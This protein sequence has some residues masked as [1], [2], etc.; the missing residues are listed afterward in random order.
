MHQHRRRG[1]RGEASIRIVFAVALVAGLLGA[2]S[3]TR[4][5]AA[6]TVTLTR[7]VAASSDD[8]RYTEIPSFTSTET[9][10][11]VGTGN[12]TRINV[13]GYRFTNISIPRGA[14]ITSVEFSMVKSGTQAGRMAVTYAFQATGNAATFSSSSTP[15][16]RTMTAA[17][18]FQDN[19]VSRTNGQRYVLGNP[20]ELAASLQQV[21]NRADWNSGNSVVLLAWGN[22]SPAW[23]RQTFRTFNSGS[24]NAPSLKITYTTAASTPTA[25]NTTV[26]P[27]ATRT[28]VPPTA[29][30]TAV[31]PTATRTPTATSTPT[32]Q[33]TTYAANVPWATQPSWTQPAGAPTP[34]AGQP[35]PVWVH[36][37]YAAQGPDGRWY[38]TWHP[39]T[40]PQY[41]CVFGH[42]HGDDPTNAP[43][44]R[45]RKP[46][47]GYA[48]LMAGMNEAHTG[49][50][51]FRWD[52]IQSVNAPSHN[53][54]SYLAVL[55]QGTSGAG[56]FTIVHHDIEVHYYRPADGREVHVHMLAPFGT[57]KA[58]CGANDP[59]MELV[60]QQQNVP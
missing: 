12:G 8:A 9:T 1:L 32:G 48:S 55:H 40:D 38:P 20:T 58:G 7:S 10:V 27:T 50:K 47:F 17:R 5:T 60:L 46:L 14:T 29:T 52:N 21:V 33:P 41:G 54:A 2:F 23:A 42:E 26:P 31:A 19:N 15:A 6:A 25:T 44:L 43:A 57:L 35:C 45:G 16:Q 30:N 4:P 34:V 22:A 3:L 24:A 28:P 11:V 56:R 53:G 51:V 49:F 59:N 13:S 37:R 39:N 18:S 36:D